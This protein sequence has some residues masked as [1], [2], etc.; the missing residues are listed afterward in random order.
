MVEM[1]FNH[2][3]DSASYLAHELKVDHVNGR[4]LSLGRALEIIIQFVNVVFGCGLW[5]RLWVWFMGVICGVVCGC[6]LWGRL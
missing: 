4:P 1:E 2:L 5:G 3:L 6:G